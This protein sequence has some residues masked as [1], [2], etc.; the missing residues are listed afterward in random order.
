MTLAAWDWP[1]AS[2]E[3]AGFAPDLGARLDEAMAT[4]LLPGLHAVVLARGGRLVLERAWPGEDERWGQPLG[5]VQHDPAQRHDLRSVTKSVVGLLYGIALARGQV[6]PPESPLAPHFPR[7]ADLFAEPARQRFTVAH[8]LTMTLGTAW[9]EGISYADPR[10]SEVAME[11]APD[12]YRY[13]L[14][15]PLVSEPGTRWI[16][17]GGCTALLGRLIADGSGQSLPDFAREALFAPLG[18]QDLEWIFGADGEPVAA[19]GLRMAPRDL[20]RVGQLVLQD[21]QWQGRQL[22]PAAW[23]AAALSPHAVIEPGLSYG[24]QWWLRRLEDGSQPWVGAFGNG[25]QRLTVHPA[26]GMVLAV[27]AG[28]YNQPEAWRLPAAVLGDYVLPALRA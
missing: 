22:V 25:G 19:S 26:L 1:L 18:I 24:Y 14:E 27:A 17:N 15:R 21:G 7:L 6:P 13:V 20:A 11:L 23:L 8:A 28:N 2:P 16:Y 12:R 10:N 9:D 5:L 4:G 3:A